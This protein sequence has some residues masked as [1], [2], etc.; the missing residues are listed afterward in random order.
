MRGFKI[1][2]RGKDYYMAC[3]PGSTGI[4]VSNK[5]NVM[6]LVCDAMDMEG[7]YLQWMTEDL[8]TDDEIII[9]YEDFD[10]SLL[11]SPLREKLV[12][13]EASEKRF[14]LSIYQQQKEQLM[15]QGLL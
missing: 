9:S 10:E 11:T 14:M 1:T 13:D 12:N 2:F 5:E 3:T 6:R 8:H 15:K 4:L 7:N